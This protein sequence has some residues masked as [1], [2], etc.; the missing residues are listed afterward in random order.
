MPAEPDDGLRQAREHTDLQPIFAA[1]DALDAHDRFTLIGLTGGSNGDQPGPRRAIYVHAKLMI[2]DDAFLTIGSCNLHLW[3][4]HVQTEMNA[5]VY[6]PAVAR[7]LR[8]E[9]FAEHLGIDTSGMKAEEAAE[10]LAEAAR[11][12]AAAGSDGHWLGNVLALDTAHNGA[13][14]RHS[15]FP[16]EHE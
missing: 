4:L 3:S 5:S 8:C 14:L 2:V 10:R 15:P 6:D 12:N 9:L 11:V 1:L 16:L 7:A 13:E